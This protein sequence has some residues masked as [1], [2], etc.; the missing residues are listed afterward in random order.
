MA[1]ALLAL[2][3]SVSLSQAQVV[4]SSKIDT[5]GGV[6][7]NIILAVLQANNIKTQDRIQLGA[8]PVVRK[9]ITA[10]EI[11]IYPEY[12]GNGAFF[13]EKA[14]DPAWKDPKQAYETVKKLDYEANKVVWLT[15][16]PAN[17]TWGI[18]LR[19][20]V[21]EANK[22][23][24]LSDFGK[25]VSGGGKV[26]LAASSEF[27]NSAAALP[28]FQTAYGF[29]LGSD[30]LITLSGGDTAATIAAAANQ[31]NG[32]NAAMVYG[33][34]GGI[35]P[36]GLVVLEDDK[37]VQPVYQPAPIIR[38][39]VLKE[40]PRIEEVL[41]PVFEKLDLVTLQDLNGRV[42]SGSVMAVLVLSASFLLPFVVVKPNRILQG[43]GR[44]FWEAL[45]G[46]ASAL[47][48]ASLVAA[49]VL[50]TLRTSPVLKIA[51][52]LACLILVVLCLGWA[53]DA[54]LPPGNSYA[55]VAPGSSFWVVLLALMLGAS[56]AIARTKP[57]PSM[58]LLLLGVALAALL[59]VL[60]SGTLG[61]VAVMRE[62]A[63]RADVF[64][65][66]ILRHATLA[67]GSML[68]AFVIGLP[69]GV[70]CYRIGWLRTWALN[71]LNILQTIPSIA[72]FG[73]LILPLG[74]LA[75]H[76]PGAAE[77]GLGGIGAAPAFVALVLYSLLPVVANTVAGLDNV[78]RDAKDAARGAGMTDGQRLMAIE[79]PLTLPS[80]LA[81]VRIVLVQNIG[82]ATI[83]AL[84]VFASRYPHQLSGGQQQRV[85]VARALAAEPKIL[86]MD[87]PFGALDPVLRRAAQDELLSIQRRF[88]TTIVIVTH[89]INEAFHLGDA[90]AV[91]DNG[92]L[93]QFAAPAELLRYPA[94]PFPPLR[95]LPRLVLLGLLL[96][97]L[98]MPDS[99][100]FLFRP[101]VQ[102]NAPAIYNQ[103]S[104]ASL[105]FQHIRIVL[106]ATALASLL[107]VILAVLVT[108][109]IGREF[110]PLAR[111]LVN[112]G[113]TFP[114]VAVLALAVPAFGFGEKPTL[115]ALFLYGLLPIFENTMTALAGVPVAVREAAR[116]NGMTGWQVL[117]QIEI[118]L[119]LPMIVG[120]IKISVVIGFGTATIG[121]TVAAK[122]LGE[123]IIAGLQSNNL[124]FV[125]QGAL[126][127]AALAVLV[128]DV[129]SQVERMLT[130]WRDESRAH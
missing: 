38:E 129:L 63:G 14:D 104:L 83:A 82:M 28:A 116:G 102:A 125:L 6:L 57:S 59:A 100:A 85:G 24:T 13:F 130:T 65:S 121:S 111:T 7:G 77:L 37:Q 120:G 45:P 110:L 115:I 97:F 22:L 76:L 41:K 80:L 88:G 114:P 117:R 84:I 119:S 122:T 49:A 128:F 44:A 43:Q 61:S 62:Y 34:D 26:V 4:V 103:G 30:Q 15:P 66:E 96:T 78:P 16:S 1:G 10:G 113:Q 70:L 75:R 67:F 79:L 21:A 105:T 36:S 68:I 19:Q 31:T 33:T 18:A 107:A 95:V 53:A 64:W 25:F 8:T 86:L 72:L 73:L 29:K 32:A 56:D 118:P 90:I 20:D 9:A 23:K 17:N 87:E 81:A 74:W 101:L 54:Q 40:N 55:R 52:T 123:V 12:T 35:A 108:R 58:R 112:V 51:G 48:A 93:L 126:L 11:D 91:M 92:K 50:L 5:E 46:S 89:D 127:V 124:A 71:S 109:P 27:V 98:G 106:I 3:M 99:F 2:S 39:A 69:F 47:L 94:S 60:G 42:Q